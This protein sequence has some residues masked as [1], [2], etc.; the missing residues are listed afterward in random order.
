MDSAVAGGQA[1][2]L[3]ELVHVEERVAGVAELEADGAGERR[4][5]GQLQIRAEPHGERYRA[6]GDGFGEADAALRSKDGRVQRVRTEII[7]TGG[8]ERGGTGTI[9]QATEEV[10][11]DSG[12]KT[13]S[14]LA[15]RAG[16]RAMDTPVGGSS[17]M[18]GAGCGSR[19]FDAKR[20]RTLAR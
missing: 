2:G 4:S 18:S 13:W 17:T 7:G 6:A 1:I 15:F 11:A 3:Y 14:P 20:A 8:V 9:N 10:E 16:T 12:T 5:R 19:R